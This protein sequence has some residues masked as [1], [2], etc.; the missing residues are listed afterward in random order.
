MLVRMIAIAVLSLV[1]LAEARAKEIELR[2][3]PAPPRPTNGFCIDKITGAARLILDRAGVVAPCHRFEITVSL[4]TLEGS[5]VCV[6][7]TTGAVRQALDKDG[8]TTLCRKSENH[9][10]FEPTRREPHS[11]T[12]RESASDTFAVARCISEHDPRCLTKC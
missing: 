7:R 3:T 6:S 12:R 11:I 4:A 8:V 5:N 2:A 9:C 10:P 1:F